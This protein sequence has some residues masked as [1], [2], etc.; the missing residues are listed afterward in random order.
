MDPIDLLR[1]LVDPARLA[2]AGVLAAAERPLDGTQLAARSG[3]DRRTCLE[4]VAVLLDAGLVTRRATGFELDAAAWRELAA[5]VALDPTPPDERIGHGMTADEQEVLGRWFEGHHLT[6]LPTNRRQRLVVLE[7]LALEFEPGRRYPEPEVNSILGRF[8]A[9]WSTLRRALVDH[10][11]LDRANNQYWRS[12]GR[13]G[14]GP[15]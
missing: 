2:V 12:G 8:N 13:V 7:R 14:A 11:F 1:L 3:T 5:D 15:A 9:D 10:G 4:T 6:R